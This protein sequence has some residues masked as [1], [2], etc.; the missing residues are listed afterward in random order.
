MKKPSP[1]T[2]K[3][4]VN[5]VSLGCPKNLVDSEVM[6][7]LLSEN[8]FAIVTPDHKSNI[9]V[10]NTCGFVEDSKQESIDT[11]LEITQKKK[12]GDVDLVVVTGCLS[13]RYKE[14]LP[15]LLPEVDL[16]IGTGEYYKLPGLIRHKMAGKSGTTYVEKPEFV[17]D[18]LTPK[19][20]LTPFYTKYVKISEGCS[21]QCSFCI[22][23][24]MR[25]TLRSRPPESIF[26]EIQTG[27]QN[28]V[29]EFNIVG[30]DLNEY[31]RDLAERS[32]L[33]K[34]LESL[35]KLE[36]DFWM[37]LMYM[38]PL[39]FPDR[40][41]ELIARHPHVLKY[42][43]IPLQHISDSM[44]KRMNRGSSG[45]Y[46][47]RLIDLLKTKVPG[48]TLRTT[49]I[50]GHPGETEE[51]FAELLQ[52]V[53]TAKFDRVGVFKYSPEDG[54]PSCTMP[55]PVPDKIKKERHDTLMAEQQKIS[56]TKN[57]SL[58]GKTVRS[59]LEG[60]SK[61]SDLLW[62]ARH[63]GQAPEIDGEILIRDGSA[64]VG[65]FCNVKIVDAFEYDLLG[66]IVG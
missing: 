62:S 52:F 48:I 4:S 8:D 37:R 36:G 53:K 59:L 60:L 11:I 6:L 25:G 12:S 30:Q 38:Y 66:E 23:P 21:H 41:V 16:F 49:F 2:Q 43:D 34:L 15:K 13:Q 22:I 5:F 56:L 51:D 19:M 18:H 26:A 47:Y 1:Q 45:K 40:L 28:G 24:Y 44:L 61:E 46:I 20:Q 35:E 3:P 54:T 33:Y 65:H 17:P 31:G 57:K 39:Q 63:A 42:V 55:D 10:I 27:I 7:G 29:K 50:V 64:P 32:S 58:V 9:T 14:E